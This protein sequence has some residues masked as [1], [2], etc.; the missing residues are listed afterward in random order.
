MSNADFQVFCEIQRF[1]FI[2]DGRF[3]FEALPF[4]NL[5]FF[6]GRTSNY[7]KDNAAHEVNKLYEK[8]FRINK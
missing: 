5:I 3:S 7:E 6:L 2:M 1:I 8:K 4:D